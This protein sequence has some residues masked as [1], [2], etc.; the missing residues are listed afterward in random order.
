M[1]V[2]VKRTRLGGRNQLLNEFAPVDFQRVT[3]AVVGAV[4]DLRGHGIEDGGMIVAQ[5]QRA[6]AAEVVHIFVSIDV[7]L[8]RPRSPIYINWMRFHVPPDVGNTVGQ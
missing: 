4:A 8:M 2:T 5:N 1:P 3:G 6:V 7:P